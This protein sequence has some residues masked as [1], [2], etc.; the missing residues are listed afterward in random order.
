MNYSAIGQSIPETVW[1]TYF[2]TQDSGLVD[3]KGASTNV[4]DIYVF[5]KT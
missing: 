4:E 1:I 2:M 5:F 3:I